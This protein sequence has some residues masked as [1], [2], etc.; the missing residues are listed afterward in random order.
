[1]NAVPD[2]D[3][4]RTDVGAYAL[5]QVYCA[6]LFTLCDGVPDQSVDMILCDLPYGTTACA[7]DTVIPFEPMWKQFKRVIQP[8]GAIVLTASQPFTS[9]LVMSN[10]KMFRY[11]WVWEKTRA[12]GY[13]NANLQPLKAHENVLVFSK[14]NAFS[15]FVQNPMSYYPEFT[16][17]V[18]WKKRG[19]TGVSVYN[20][21]AS[22]ENDLVRVSDGN[23][24]PRSVI[25]FANPNND[26][27]HPTQKP[28]ALFRYLI[29]TYTRPTE[30][31][32]DPCVGSG[33]TAM[34]AREEGRNFIC[35]DS[36]AE[37]VALANKRLAMPFTP[38]MFDF[39][40][41]EHS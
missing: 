33:T 29:R 4:P 26:N 12:A 2:F 31:V 21:K 17:G 18:P 41:E 7:W 35:G 14:A 16:Q 38:Q 10:P 1:M 5:N 27:C 6:D 32:L 24:F 39:T 25:E 36:N 30:L 34:A 40:Q 37:Y 22:L 20:G 28:V 13:P 8:R 19:R 11:E 3:T 15:G 23:R 9:A